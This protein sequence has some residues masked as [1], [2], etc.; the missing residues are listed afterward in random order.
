MGLIVVITEKRCNIVNKA[1]SNMYKNKSI[2]VE[3]GY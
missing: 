2:R 3:Y 1:I